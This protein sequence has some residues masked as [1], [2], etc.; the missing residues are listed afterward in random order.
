MSSLWDNFKGGPLH[1]IAEVTKKALK[2]FDQEH[3]DHPVSPAHP[4]IASPSSSSPCR[5]GLSITTA[6][7]FEGTL[8]EKRAL[9]YMTG[10]RGGQCTYLLYN[11]LSRLLTVLM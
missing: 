3:L 6:C 1:R 5:P 10:T 8:T 11:S 9:Y 2:N 4:A 7:H